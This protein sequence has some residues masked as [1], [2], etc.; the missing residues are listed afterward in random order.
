METTI[1]WVDPDK[2]LPPAHTALDDPPGLVA[3]GLDLSIGRL[4]QAYSEGIFPWFNPG[5][6]VL[7]WS[8]N[9]RAVLYCDQLHLSRSLAKRMRKI[10]RDQ[11]SG[12]FFPCVVTVDCA[13]P[14]VMDACATRGAPHGL[15]PATGTW[16]TQEMK[17]VYQQWHLTGR[18]HSIETW[19]DGE[20]SGGLYGVSIGRMFFGESMF[21]RRTDASKIALVHLVRFLQQQRVQMIDC[22]MTT[23]HLVSLGA[24]E[25]DRRQFLDHV[26]FSTRQPDIGWHSGWIDAN[27]S[28]HAAIP[29]CIRELRKIS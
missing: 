20:L 17:H 7:W 4:E 26:R 24:R 8:P 18:A 2:P 16:I 12:N 3:A 22:Q 23:R 29:D 28:I 14:A 27:G 15:P 9:P 13:F 11:A 6:P 25:I 5:E 10:E 1:Q 19:T 21:T